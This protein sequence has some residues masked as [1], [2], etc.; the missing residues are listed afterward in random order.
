MTFSP[1]WPGRNCHAGAKEL[2]MSVFS[3]QNYDFLFISF[4]KSYKNFLSFPFL[5]DFFDLLLTAQHV[6]ISI[7]LKKTIIRLSYTHY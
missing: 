1:R 2:L 6:F 3:V 5:I 7:I 4:S